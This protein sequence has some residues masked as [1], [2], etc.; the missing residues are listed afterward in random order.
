MPDFGYLLFLLSETMGVGTM[1]SRD[2]M[3]LDVVKG[4]AV[5]MM[6]WGHCIQYCTVGDVFF[7]ENPVM[8]AIYSFHMPI[9]MMVSG[10]LFH[11]SFRKRNLKELL[12]HR[13]QGMLQPIIFGT[14]MANLLQMILHLV[15]SVPINLTDGSLL[16]GVMELYWFLWCVLASSVAVGIACK[17]TQNRWLQTILLCAGCFFVALFPGKNFQMFMYPYFVVGF[18]WAKHREYLVK[19]TKPVRFLALLIF[20]AIL[21]YFRP[22]H[23]IYVTPMYSPEL[24][25]CGS[26]EVAAFRFLIGL[27]GSAFV[28]VLLE[29]LFCLIEKKA[30]V[31][32]ILAGISRLGENS[33]QIYVL[34][35]PL[36]SIFLPVV[37]DKITSILGY[38]L[39][40]EN[41]L[42][43]GLVYTPLLSMGYAAGIY[44]VI[45]LM[46]KLRIDTLV[47]GR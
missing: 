27:A 33:L 24:G 30:S 12:I 19:L 34:S 39:F 3:Y 47:F 2:R 21:P 36:L 38:P 28:L 22:K 6:L 46:K 1:R 35:A 5:F 29:L 42:L 18:L 26:L 10:Y 45:L 9:F 7:L 8:K 41:Q 25:L 43:L 40:G 37:Y 16:S 23:T 31:P 11:F 13:T 14:V 15:L 32:G 20:P 4:I 17:I 44:L